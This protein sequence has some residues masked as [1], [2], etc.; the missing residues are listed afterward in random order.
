MQL[1][2]DNSQILYSKTDLTNPNPSNIQAVTWSQ[3][4]KS[5]TQNFVQL[6]ATL[7]SD[8]TSPVMFF[9]QQSLTEQLLSV[10]K[11]TTEG[12]DQYE[13]VVQPPMFRYGQDSATNTTFRFL[14]YLDSSFNIYQNRFVNQTTVSKLAALA[15][16]VPGAVPYANEA[17][18][19]IGVG[20]SVFG[21]PLRSFEG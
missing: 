18:K 9:V 2:Q 14:V 20:Q 6:T 10:S 21:D 4:L 5:M 17:K 8:N 7:A 15:D 13:A 11:P 3:S 16:K 19:L 1:V 12:G